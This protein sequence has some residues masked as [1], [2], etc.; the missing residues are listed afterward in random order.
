MDERHSPA[1]ASGATASALAA[2]AASALAAAA[3]TEQLYADLPGGYDV[4]KEAALYDDSLTYGEIATSDLALL[5]ERVREAR[6]GADAARDLT[7]MPGA[8]GPG[9]RRAALCGPRLRRRQAGAGRCSRVPLL[10]RH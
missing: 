2:A 1:E 5:C 9:S 3:A 10:H 4:D 8:A 6:S 7:T